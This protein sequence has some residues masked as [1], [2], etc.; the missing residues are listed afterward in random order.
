MGDFESMKNGEYGYFCEL[1]GATPRNRIL[2]FF[3][4]MRELDFAMSDIIQETG[5]NKATA[6]NTMEELV[7]HQII[8]PTRTV[9]K[10]QLYKLNMK[11]DDV[12]LLMDIFNR[13]LKKMAKK[14]EQEVV[15]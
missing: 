12:Q 2:E 15:C 8:I 13:I 1:F 14:H 5:L 9:G 10:T 4:E 3:L 7:K 6:Y 11:R